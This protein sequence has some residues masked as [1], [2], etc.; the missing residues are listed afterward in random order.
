[1][2]WVG[3]GASYLPIP[4]PKLQTH[5]LVVSLVLPRKGAIYMV[6]RLKLGGDSVPFL[7]FGPFSQYVLPSKCVAPTP[8]FPW[9]SPRPS[10]RCPNKAQVVESTL[11]RDSSKSIHLS[12]QSHIP[13]KFLRST[14]NL[15]EVR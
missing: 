12:H 3:L 7:H 15:I 5:T 10:E 14:S 9:L 1:M 6:P 13:P 4:I 2:S 11:V 8:T